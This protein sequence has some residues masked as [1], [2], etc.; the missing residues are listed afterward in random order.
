[1][2]ID[3][4]YH[5]TQ[6]QRER[7]EERGKILEAYTLHVLRFTN[8]EILSNTSSVLHAISQYVLDHTYEQSDK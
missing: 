1:V 7:D 4:G 5:E 8:A 3:G 6:A 2:E